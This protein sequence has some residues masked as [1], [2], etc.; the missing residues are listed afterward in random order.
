ME[1]GIRSDSEVQDFFAQSKHQE[2]TKKNLFG[3]C[4]DPPPAE[5]PAYIDESD[6]QKWIAIVGNRHHKAITFTAIDH[7]PEFD[8]RKEDGKQ[9]SRCDGVISVDESILFVELKQRK[10]RKSKDWLD[11]G[12]T[13]LKRTIYHFSKSS[14]AVDFKHRYVYIANSKKPKFYRGQEVRMN[15]FLKETGYVLRIQNRIDIE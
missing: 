13:Q 4:D 15:N 10:G 8:F 6:E 1:Q 12:E 2:I 11:D 7:C 5:K 9:D 14:D 3:L